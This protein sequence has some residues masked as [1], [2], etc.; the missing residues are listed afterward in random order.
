MGTVNVHG[1]DQ[2]PAGLSSAEARERL[3]NEG[4]NELPAARRRS[5]FALLAGVVREPMF[6]MLIACGLIYLMLGSI[7]DAL[8]LLGFVVVIIG[9]TLVQEGRTEHALDALRDLSSPRAL[10]VRDGSQ[11]RIAGREVVRGDVILV[12]E[13][14]RVPADAELLSCSGL[15]TDE[16]LLTGESFPVRKSCGDGRRLPVAPG[17]DDLPFIY[18]GSLV[19]G[20]RAIALVTS[21]GPRTEIGK[22]GKALGALHP[23]SSLLQRQMGLL[24]RTVGI[25]SVILCLIVTVAY[26]LTR[27]DWLNG[28]LAG[29]TLAM[30]TL[31]EEFPM[32]LVVFL[33][34]GAWRLSRYRVLT[35]R[36]PAVEMLGAASVLCVDKTGTLTENRMTVRRI[37]VEGLEYEVDGMGDS[38]PESVHEAVEY[39]I[40]ASPPDPFDPMEKAMLELGEK[41]LS[42]TEHLH[43]DWVLEK[44]Y[45]LSEGMLAISHAWRS[46]AGE[47]YVIAAKGA[48]E[49]IADLCHFDAGRTELLQASIDAIAADGMRVIG[50]AKAS[51]GPG[52]LPEERH[53]YAFSFIGLLGLEDPVRQGVPEA[54][55][56]CREAGI[57]MIMMT[58]DYPATARRIGEQI[59]LQGR[60]HLVTG[61]QLE[62]MSRDELHEAI[63]RTAIFARMRPGQKLGIV[64]AL[65]ARREVVAMT[66]DGVNDAPALKAAHI[67]IA[68][69][70]RGTDVAREAAA[71]VLVDDHFE[72]IVRAVRMGRRIYDN[73]RKAMVFILSVHL[74]I[75]GMSLFPVLLNWPLALLPAHILFLE[76]LIDPSCS[77]VFEMERDEPDIMRRPPR[78]LDEPLVGRQVL[79][80]SLFQGFAIFLAVFGVYALML[81]N[82]YGAGE[83]RMIAFGGIVAGNIGL[84]FANRSW[85]QSMIRSLRIPNSALWWVTAGAILFFVLSTAVPFMRGLFRFDPP[86][87]HQLPP[88]LFLCLVCFFIP[89]FVKSRIFRL[90]FKS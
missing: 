89:D 15:T 3:R 36:M 44:E 84:I 20:G 47:G 53:D 27:H 17:G 48:P 42:D 64:E 28:L 61:G 83:A 13:G 10:V 72:S 24:V 31:P 71:I 21:T 70:G 14:D 59:G 57:R 25:F 82:G 43:R 22:I 11:V 38:L 79:L 87:W 86:E 5:F 4:W 54:L 30:A 90:W 56:E 6:L 85:D 80:R 69:G 74:P 52:P 33:A 75:A 32:V 73:L 9:I 39:S 51:F 78:S 12:S 45:P 7:E 49:A 19:V 55:K 34:L 65:K 66:G 46:T 63:G 77:I 23:E 68:M 88:A 35:R 8:M 37:F 50:V 62:L 1:S 58:G 81:S 18:S 60:E 16:S 67:G 76:L 2:L 29:L 26:G 41:A 40:L